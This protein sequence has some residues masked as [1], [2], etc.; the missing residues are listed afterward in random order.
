MLVVDDDEVFRAIVCAQLE[1]EGYVTGEAADGRAGVEAGLTWDPAII[2]LD[3]IMPE[4]DGIEA[5]RQIRRRSSVPI[6]M[7]TARDN[8]R[9]RV[10][11]LDA[12]ADDYLSKPF[13]TSELTARI[14]AVLR[15]S[16]TGGEAVESDEI[17]RGDIRLIPSKRE[18]TVQDRNVELSP[19][20]YQLLDRLLRQ[21]DRAVE[22]RNLLASA[23]GLEYRDDIGALR[24]NIARLRA[25]LERD[26]SH[27][28]YLK[29]VRGVG[30][31]VSSVPHPDSGEPRSRSPA[32]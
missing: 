16:V 25:K 8:P 10:Q 14:R 2:L 4:L 15:R 19:R 32:K 6:I 29:T 5:C 17:T 23:W 7:L 26:P 28:H 20:E 31:M 22:Y 9:D 27:P 21:P 13:S 18:V 11:G 3:V 30:Y 24:V 1:Q 12:G